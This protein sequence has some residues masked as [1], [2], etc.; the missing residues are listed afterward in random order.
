MN[1]I[2]LVSKS[3]PEAVDVEVRLRI[4]AQVYVWLGHKQLPVMLSNV[5]KCKNVYV[6]K[7]ITYDP[8][9]F[10]QFILP[11]KTE[12]TVHFQAEGEH[13][14]VYIVPSIEDY[15]NAGGLCGHIQSDGSVVR[16][17]R[18]GMIVHDCGCNSA[19]AEFAEG[20]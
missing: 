8:W 18:N 16:K 6:Y 10:F 11:T 9:W 15:Q 3:L 1:I 12:I 14:D 17:L 13:H 7:I 19:C 5:I 4:H 2:D 20:W